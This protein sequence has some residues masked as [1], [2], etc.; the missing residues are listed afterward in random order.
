METMGPGKYEHVGKSQA[1]LI[2]INPIIFTRT[3]KSS[4]SGAFRWRGG[5]P[6]HARAGDRGDG[7]AGEA[8]EGGEDVGAGD[9]AVVGGA[10]EGG[11]EE[12]GAV[13]EA[14]HARAAFP[15]ILAAV[16]TEIHLCNV[17][18]CP[19]IL[20]SSQDREAHSRCLSTV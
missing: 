20:T 19:E 3:R 11:W 13:H 16:L 7:H 15:C 2:M 8:T 17:C 5:G 18:S 4:A 14:A 1:V 9:D 12:V 6:S 10:N